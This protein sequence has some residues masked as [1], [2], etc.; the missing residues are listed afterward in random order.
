MTDNT[1]ARTDLVPL[2][3]LDLSPIT[4]GGTAAQSLD[5]SLDLARHAERWGSALLAPE[6]ER[7]HLPAGRCGTARV[8]SRACSGA[9]GQGRPWSG[10][11]RAGLDSRLESIWRAAGCRAWAAVRLRVGVRAGAD[12]GG[13]DWAAD[14]SVL[15]LHPSIRISSKRSSRRS[16]AR[17]SSARNHPPWWDHQRRFERASLTLSGARPQTS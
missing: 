7:R 17:I 2:S 15:C 10:S 13:C 5:H 14:S 1:R 16:S 12:D 8:L 9:A 3:V 4:Q 6:P 11:A